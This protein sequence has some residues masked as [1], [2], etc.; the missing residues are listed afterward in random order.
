MLEKCNIEAFG[1]RFVCYFRGGM[2]NSDGILRK[3]LNYARDMEERE[4]NHVRLQTVYL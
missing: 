2:P 3:A 1:L 4:F